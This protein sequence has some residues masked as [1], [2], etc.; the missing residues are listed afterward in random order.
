LLLVKLTNHPEVLG[1]LGREAGRLLLRGFVARIAS[2]APPGCR[3]YHLH[4]ETFGLI[5]PPGLLDE[6]RREIR[7]AVREPVMADSVPVTISV[8]LGRADVPEHAQDVDVLVQ[9]AVWAV[10]SVSGPFQDEVVY[11]PHQDRIRRE[12]LVLLSGLSEAIADEQLRLHYQPQFD[13]RTG[14]LVGAEALV[15]WQHQ[16]LGLLTPERFIPQA[17][18]TDLISDLTAWGLTTALQDAPRLGQGL[19]PWTVA[20]NLSANTLLD[21]DLLPMLDATLARTG[22][23][24]HHLE[25]EVTESAVLVDPEEARRVLLQVRERGIGIAI[26]DFGTGSTSLRYL[27]QLPASRV[28]VDRWFV[29]RLRAQE[30][31]RHIVAAMTGLG[32][33]LGM[34]VLAEGVEDEETLDL[35]RDLGCDLA[36]GY[37]LGRP[38]P[39]ERFVAAGHGAP[40]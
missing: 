35:L 21:P 11:D 19:Q 8:S 14:R 24:P 6:V 15:R 25:V 1:V 40:A 23:A 20:V 16:H 3:V 28:K 18:A 22:V 36:Q 34:S 10:Q 4:G 39:L 17:E 37:L 7:Q 33:Q 2:V 31:D 12:N 26:D 38:V 27:E 32:H 13:L 5:V 30:S 29:A 9:Q